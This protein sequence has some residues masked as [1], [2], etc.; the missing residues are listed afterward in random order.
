M[1][2]YSASWGPVPWVVYVGEIF[3]TRLRAYGV[4]LGS[5]TQWL[6][7][8]VITYITPA[9]INDIG[10]RTFIMFGTFCFAMGVW[11]FLFVRETKGRSL[12]EMDVL[13]TRAL[14]L[15]CLRDEEHRVDAK[16]ADPK[17]ESET[18]KHVGVGRV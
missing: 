11:V 13:C 12:E 8:F 2:G 17:A 15:G 16:I 6:F 5:A 3:P 9:A 10:W 1:I 7:N 14:A 4:G 18:V